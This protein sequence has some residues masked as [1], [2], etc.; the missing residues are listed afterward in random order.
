MASRIENCEWRFLED[1]TDDGLGG[2]IPKLSESAKRIISGLLTKNPEQRMTA[3]TLCNDP[4]LSG[5]I[6]ASGETD[7]SLEESEEGWYQNRWHGRYHGRTR[8]LKE[9]H[10]SK[11]SQQENSHAQN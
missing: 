6:K 3:E 1:G 11:A 2:T 9:I 7:A 4:W 5:A 10:Y 8:A